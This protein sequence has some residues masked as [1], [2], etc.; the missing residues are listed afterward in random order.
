M[1][2][3]SPCPESCNAVVEELHDGVA[4]VGHADTVAVAAVHVA[5]HS[6]VD[7]PGVL[8]PYDEEAAR[9]ATSLAQWP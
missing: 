5:H 7:S 3:G 6:W 4:A 1:D 2:D 9:A 8:V